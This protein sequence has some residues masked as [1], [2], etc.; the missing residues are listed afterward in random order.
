MIRKRLKGTDALFESHMR[1]IADNQSNSL[2]NRLLDTLRESG[3]ISIS[4]GLSSEGVNPL[5]NFQLIEF[6]TKLPTILRVEDEKDENEMDLGTETET[7]ERFLFELGFRFLT[8]CELETFDKDFIREY[9]D[10]GFD[11]NVVNPQNQMTALHQL[12]AIRAIEQVEWLIDSGRCDFLVSN[13][14]FSL[15]HE[16]AFPYSE[17][18]DLCARLYALEDDQARKDGYQNLEEWANSENGPWKNRATSY[19]VFDPQ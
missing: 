13:W 9:I 7:Q 19:L 2:R 1:L 15:P 10:S 3:Q 14:R 12:T 8:A 4:F 5:E 18:S 11:L 16:L 17:E 6:I